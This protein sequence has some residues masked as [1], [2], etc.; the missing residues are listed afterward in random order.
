MKLASFDIFDTVLIRKCGKPVNIFYLLAH[1]LY[2]SDEAKRENFI[3]WR[4]GAESR[5]ACNKRGQETTIADIYTNN[6]EDNFQEYTPAQLIEAE[7]QVESDNLIANPAIKAIIEQCRAE[8]KKICFISD[9]YLD[10]EFLASVLRREG[11]LQNDEKVFVSCEAGARKSTGTLYDKVRE[12]L[13]PA[14]WEHYGD[15]AVS[16]IK[17]A[18]EKRIKAHYVNTAFTESEKTLSQRNRRFGYELSCLAGLQRAARIAH[19]ND[20]YTALAADFVAPAYIPYV[21]FIFEKAKEQNIKRLY[22]LSRDSYI[23]QKIAEQMQ[24]E[25]PGIELKYLFVS[26]KALLLPY[27]Q[28]PTANKF[29]AVQDKQTIIGKSTEELLK[30]LGTTREKLEEEY[31]TTFNYSKIGNREEE[32][33]FLYKI[34]DEKSDFLSHLQKAATE[35]RTKLNAYFEQEGL[36]D[37]TASAMVDVGWLGTTRLMINSILK[38]EGH[39]ETLFFYYGVRRDV[40]GG[41]YGEFSTYFNAQEQNTA[42]TTVI[43][44]YFSASPYPTT[45]GYEKVQSGVAPMFKQGDMYKENKIVSANILASKF[46]AKEIAQNNLV[47][48]N[49]LKTWSKITTEDILSLKQKDIN[50][51]PLCDCETFDGKPFVRKL[52]AKELAYIVLLGGRCTAYD[53]ASVRLTAGYRLFPV[54]WSICKVTGKIRRFLYLKLKKR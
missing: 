30:S 10:S 1:R 8:G 19:G 21:R 3:T 51:T 33:D 27:M 37:G 36:F 49:L 28:Q 54:I 38:Q 25:F 22:F 42:L 52:S 24:G 35:E 26:R 53:N 9:M 34:F 39:K 32:Q 14:Q 4:R 6:G 2:P 45:I 11:C 15:N 44:N 46:L 17:K 29:L 20:A 12:Q 7:K 40:L 13:S 31:Q 41:E 43:E 5:V 18:K 48:P 23:L 47:Q 50:V 16:D